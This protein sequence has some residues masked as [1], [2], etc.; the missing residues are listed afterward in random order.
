MKILEVLLEAAKLDFDDLSSLKDVVTSKIK[1]LPEDDATARALKEIQDLLNHIHSGGKSGIIND[2]LQQIPD[3]T[4][5]S[6]QKMLARYLLSIEMTPEQRDELFKLWK[7]DKL[8]NKSKLLTPGK[9]NLNDIV[10]GYDKN[11]AIEEFVNDMM[12][13]AALG[14]GKGEFGSRAAERMAQGNGSAVHVHLVLVEA[15]F[16][17]NGQALSREG[18]VQLDQIDLIQA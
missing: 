9:H 17:N 11:P 12:K 3:P 15:Q 2:K 16:A 18:F 7:N 13:V 1:D 8:I 6:A 5:A 10:T 4:V 14:Q